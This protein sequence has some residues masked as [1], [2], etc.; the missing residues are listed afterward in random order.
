MAGRT[1][2]TTVCLETHFSY[3][4]VSLGPVPSPRHIICPVYLLSR[5]QL[6]AGSPM[7]LTAFWVSQGWRGKGQKGGGGG[8]GP[9]APP[10]P[11]SQPDRPKLRAA[12]P[13][14][15]PITLSSPPVRVGGR[16]MGPSGAPALYPQK[17]ERQLAVWWAC[18]GDNYAERNTD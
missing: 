3:E 14:L 13:T 2:V 9:S 16:I 10:F 7:P 8:R 11:L 15:P 12:D 5:W 1:A 17:E 18:E 6:P 4:L